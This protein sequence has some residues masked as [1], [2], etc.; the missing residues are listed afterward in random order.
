MKS[1]SYNPAESQETQTMVRDAEEIIEEEDV[2][3]ADIEN[4]EKE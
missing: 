4:A 1:M 3:I 2:I